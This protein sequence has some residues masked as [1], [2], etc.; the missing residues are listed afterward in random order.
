MKHI[1]LS[2]VEQFHNLLKLDHAELS[3][4]A[5]LEKENYDDIMK[6]I[7]ILHSAILQM[8]RLKLLLEPPL[9][10]QPKKKK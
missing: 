4:Q 9:P 3:Q 2:S 7:S 1:N 5:N 10:P 6:E 8:N